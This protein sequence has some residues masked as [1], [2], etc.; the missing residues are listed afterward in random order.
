M[1]A[2]CQQCADLEALLVQYMQL[3]GPTDEMR[4]YFR[5]GPHPGA[6][7]PAATSEPDRTDAAGTDVPPGEAG[8]SAP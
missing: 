6:G 4:Q 5:D 7:V 2:K 1:M 8:P 3:L